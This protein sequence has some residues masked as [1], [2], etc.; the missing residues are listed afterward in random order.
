MQVRKRMKSHPQSCG[1][2]TSHQLPRHIDAKT[3]NM[4]AGKRNAKKLPNPAYMLKN[5]RTCWNQTVRV[6]DKPPLTWTVLVH[7]DRHGGMPHLEG[8]CG[9]EQGSALLTL[10]KPFDSLRVPGCSRGLKTL[11]LEKC[12][13]PSTHLLRRSRKAVELFHRHAIHMIPLFNIKSHVNC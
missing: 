11:M 4:L 8:L 6:L 12:L 1:K 9:Q 10:S 13:L 7:S 5:F 2:R 3:K